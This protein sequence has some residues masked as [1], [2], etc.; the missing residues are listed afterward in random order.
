M[1]E[2]G[3]RPA[4]WALRGTP[5]VLAGL[6]GLPEQEP[7]PISWAWG[8]SRAQHQGPGTAW[9][10]VDACLHERLLWQRVGKKG[11]LGSPLPLRCGVRSVRHGLDPLLPYS[12]LPA[13]AGTAPET[14]S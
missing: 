10:W 12:S 9:R 8:V 7:T 4:S 2:P 3:L 14:R 13:Q 1:Q 5:R 6:A 11:G